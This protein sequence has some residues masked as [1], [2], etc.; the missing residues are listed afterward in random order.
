MPAVAAEIPV[1]PRKPV[2]I[3]ITKKMRAHLSM[4][5]LRG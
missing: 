5:E 3:E 1:K 2:M 4:G